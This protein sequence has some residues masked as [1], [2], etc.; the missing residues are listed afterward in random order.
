MNLIKAQRIILTVETKLI[1]LNTIEAYLRERLCPTGSAQRL[2][3]VN[4]ALKLD[5]AAIM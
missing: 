5:R 2:Q 3:L 4:V 1:K